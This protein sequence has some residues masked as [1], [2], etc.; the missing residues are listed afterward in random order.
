MEDVFKAP[1]VNATNRSF[2]DLFNYSNI[3]VNFNPH[4]LLRQEAI[5]YQYY[6]HL[7]LHQP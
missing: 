2:Q 7:H 5:P 6:C 4:I 1:N 3:H